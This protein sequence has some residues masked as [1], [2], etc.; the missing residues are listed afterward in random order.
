[1]K[2]HE[3]KE[4]RVPVLFTLLFGL[5]ASGVGIIAIL[6]WI[7][8]V[9]VLASFSYG[10]IPMAPSTA[11]LFISFG[12]AILLH[13]R[14]SKSSW[15]YN[16][17]IIIG[18]I[19][20]LIAL[21]LF[22]LSSF[23]IHLAVEHLGFKIEGSITGAPFGYISPLTALCFVLAGLSF[24][25][26]LSSSEQRKQ[27][28]VALSFAFSVILVSI[29]LLLAHLFGSPLL[30]GTQF[31]PPALSTSL[32]FFFLGIALIVLMSPKIWRYKSEHDAASIRSS[33]I[34][35]LVF[36]VLAVGIISVGYFY[37]THNEKEYRLQKEQEL[38]S[39]ADLK[40]SELTRI[41]KEWIEDASLFYE[42]TVFS[43]LVDRYFNNPKDIEA[44]RQLR[45]WLSQF[46]I[47]NQYNNL[48]LHDAKGIERFAL[49]DSPGPHSSVF[50]DKISEAIKS[51]KI[52]IADFYRNEYDQ[53]IYL[54]IFVPILDPKNNSRVNGVLSLRID[55]ESY[56]YPY[57]KSWPTQSK[58]SE[59]IL[60]RREGDDV[61]YL[62]ELRFKKNTALTA[63]SL[64]NKNVPAVRAVLGEQGIVEGYDYRGVPV[65]ADIHIIQNSPWFI[66]TKIDMAEVYAPLSERLW[67]MIFL[68]T[69]LLF[70]SGT[71]IA[72]V[73]RQQR[74][75][76]YKERYS[77][78]ERIQK[79]NRIYAVLS[80]INQV[81][82]R[83][84]DIDRLFNE[85][86]RIAVEDGKF[87]MVWIGM[88][89]TDSK[90]VEVAASAGFTSDYLAKIN[91]D[92]N[93]EKRS[94]G[95]TGRTIISG[96]HFISNDIEHDESMIPWRD[97]AKKHGYKSSASFPIKVFGKVHGVFNMYSSEAGF[98]DEDEIKLLDELA[99]DISFALEFI[100]REA[101]RKEAE[102]FLLKFRMGIERSGD[103]V[104]LTNPDG[105]IVYVNP[106]FE[107]IFGYTKEEA[108][109]KTPRI[110]KSNTLNQEYYKNFWNDL[111]TK[112]PVIHEIVNK[113]KD[114]RQLS[115]EAS[116]N[117]II[118]KQNEIIGFLAIERDITERKQA[119]E[120]LQ[121]SEER[122][123]R[124][125]EESTDPILLLDQKYFFDCNP[126]AL[127]I[128]QLKSKDE[129]GNKTPWDLSPE[130]QPDG[131]LSS[132]KAVEMI[133]TAKQNGYHRFEWVHTKKDG[134]N[135]FVEV[136][137]TPI[138]LHG[139]EIF[140]VIWRDITDRKRAEESLRKSEEQ[141]ELFFTQSLAGFFFMMLDEPISWDKAE[142]K[143]KALDYIITHQRITKVNDAMLAQYR[144]TR[145]QF[146][147]LT[148]ADFFTHDIEQGRRFLRQLFDTGHLHVETD[149]RR[150]DGTQ[151]WAEG[152]YICLY[153][154]NRCITGQFGV[155]KDI[156]ER[157]RAEEALQEN[158]ERLRTI[159]ETEPE[160]V[161]IVDR[162]GQLL[163]MN[164]AGLAMLEAESLSEV[165]QR[166]LLNFILP[167]YRASFGAMHKRVMSGE[168]G[169]LEFEVM[170][171]RG[172]RRWLETHAAPMRDAT[173]EVVKLLGVTRDI[174]ERKLTEE[175]LRD[176][177]N[178]YRS[179]IE[180]ASEG[181]IIYDM[182]TRRV[183]DSN[184]AYQKL[185]GYTAA[186][187]REL[188][189]YDIVIPNYLG[190]DFM[191]DRI[192]T[193]KDVW[194]GE[195][196]HRRKDGSK[197]DVEASSSLNIYRGKEVFSVIVR[198]IT[199]RKRAEEALRES[200]ERFRN[201]VE[202]IN[203]VFYIADGQGKIF[204]CS[205][206]ITTA[207]G[208]SLKEIIGKSFLRLIAP[209]DRRIVSD[210]Y[211]DQSTKGVSDTTLVFRVRCKDGKIIWAEQ[212]TRI[213]YDTFGNVVEYR[214]VAR[215]ITE[216]KRAEETLQRSERSYRGLVE[217][218]SDIIY[219]LVED[220]TITSLNLAFEK[221]TGWLRD[222]WIGKLFMSIIHPEDLPLAIEKFQQSM[223]GE[224]PSRYE[225]R[226]LSK[227]GGYLIGEFTSMPQIEK[228]KVGG[229]V[230]DI[231]ERKRAEQEIISQKNRFAQLFENS[232]IAIALL[233]DQ[234]KIIHI[235]ESF[236]ALFGYFLEEVKGQSL[237]DIIVPPELKEEAESYSDQ[238][239]AGNQINKENYR[240]KKD[241][242]LVYVQI[243]GVP[244]NINDKT[245]GIY[246]MYVDMT[247]RKEAEEKMK[248][249]KELAEQ[250]DK[251]K[252][253]FLAQMS[254]EI[255]TPMN[256]MLG[257]VDY[258][259][260]LFG[261]KMDSEARHC[262]D[263]IHLASRRIIRTIDLI[264][265]VSELQTSGY[266]PQFVKIDLNSRILNK[267]YHEHQLSAKQK[268]LELIYKCELKETK[269]LA[270]EY[271]VTQI[272]AN[273]ID[274][275]VKYTKKGT[276]EILLGKNISGNIMVEIKDT[277]I[278]M[279]KEFLPSIFE[280]FLQ[281]DQGYSRSFEGNGLGLALVKRYCDI[282]NAV[283]EV[284]SEKNVGSTFR[285]IFSRE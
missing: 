52:T 72:V 73:W 59:T 155:Q 76:F 217:S 169:V 174:T 261:E 79:L 55:P 243:V 248:I 10:L 185:L 123:R 29:I 88:V 19:S 166:T 94:Q 263:G 69:A 111:L 224:I 182:A 118:N 257:N 268:G 101:Q 242:T 7:L 121:E 241:G 22:F 115:I 214:N 86:C 273:L 264:L 201:L 275:A 170:G 188:T 104:L 8:G 149:E 230:R 160:C 120:T 280:P 137:L 229:I 175:A 63:V 193:E 71:S 190:V 247:Q 245:V 25:I 148:L 92:L 158:E 33:I 9:P 240:K 30:Y 215:D 110:L 15:F 145:E 77:D 138:A 270:D 122:F 164:A 60:V 54:N 226:C 255:R 18:S 56:L 282:N 204:Y 196:Q 131:K 239:R 203:E 189:I 209:I 153:D 276:V 218:A 197:V 150:F 98:F 223:H 45:T 119:E 28:L 80:N 103:A 207:T 44:H 281:E 227:A 183:L 133:L 61:L 128:L 64:K 278:G 34:L 146:I 1:M 244:V 238:T 114:G 219:T 274:N 198:D 3:Q 177:E 143:E 172:T 90:K 184:P 235:N 93:D 147:G 159:I 213:V 36:G 162:D 167:E 85:I 134:T 171:L 163:E 192:K 156:T 20:T 35:I 127:S 233:D 157:K 2:T 78:A 236:S 6:G 211:L 106:A 176:S 51:G 53:H 24:L 97:D 228:G 173:G 231:T 21:L 222:E 279:S 161:K 283:I 237:N 113:T 91:I 31:I 144:A 65:L 57:I 70:G 13:T 265:N 89:N 262:F 139:E 41:R 83:V 47:V 39:V 14:F 32:A 117:P 187:M 107:N 102:E 269:I 126:A 26:S 125:F 202:N 271:S 250:S 154:A 4:K 208:Y 178:R 254:H 67:L 151:M 216:R 46:K 194:I 27:M 40:I 108:I 135:F 50:E 109:G 75:Q 112:K 58:T 260:D 140:H 234:D 232:P 11:F 206:S 210:H 132:E 74:V 180:H 141:L 96:S 95:P 249:A 38:S 17:G 130:F 23:G 285:V 37:Y 186:E 205:P 277:G 212:I 16:T 251:L 179:V 99:M 221:I 81:I 48:C 267:L 256:I 272:F 82:V 84:H 165:Q 259:N 142:D 62:N 87:R 220:G 49:P 284:E 181:I 152:D 253:E 124:L 258:L 191:I 129:I 105:T 252:S 42:N 43:T 136:M 200:E 5:L 266:K 168:N 195:R 246:G 12:A 68:I 100:E 199:E 225:L 66:V 116:I